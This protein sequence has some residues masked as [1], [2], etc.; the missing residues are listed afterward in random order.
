MQTKLTIFDL[1]RKL[2]QSR[3][4]SRTCGMSLVWSA[5]VQDFPS[6]SLLLLFPLMG[7]VKLCFGILTFKWIL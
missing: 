6:Y 2:T 1:Y 3:S 5:R 4:N 7:V